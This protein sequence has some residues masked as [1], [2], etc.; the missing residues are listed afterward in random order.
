MTTDLK[1]NYKWQNRHKYQDEEQEEH[2]VHVVLVRQ[3]QLQDW[4]LCF[5]LQECAKY[6]DDMLD[7]SADAGTMSADRTYGICDYKVA[8]W[9]L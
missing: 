2:L 6:L 3:H 7:M 4:Q 8:S 5:F 9:M 1:K